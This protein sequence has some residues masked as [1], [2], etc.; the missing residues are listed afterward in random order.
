MRKALVVGGNGFIGSHL[1]D[2]L[3]KQGW[4]VAVLD[5][6]ERRYEPAPA[7]VEYIQGDLSQSYLVREAVTGVDIVFHLAWATI[8]EVSNYDPAADVHANLIP[9]LHLL[10]ACRQAEVHRIVFSSSGGTVYGIPQALPITEGHPHYPINAYGITKLAVEKYLHMFWHLYGLEYVV[11]RP[12]VPYGPRQNPLGRQGAAA[13]FLYRV[14]QGL[15]VTIWGDGSVTRDYFYIS[16]LVTALLAAAGQKLNQQCI[17]NL[18]GGQEISLN[19][20]LQMVEETVGKKAVVEYRPGRKF[21]AT[22]LLLDTQ[23][24]ARELNWQPQVSLASGL[25]QTW[26][27]MSATLEIHD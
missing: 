25:A 8:H 12:S 10:E 13:V 15:P 5:L 23:L 14:A 17:F 18:G 22:R 21:D 11:L 6:H 3:V 27:W 2:A 24:A 19:Q 7:S 9:S 1:V 4:K 20:L 26:A 16:D